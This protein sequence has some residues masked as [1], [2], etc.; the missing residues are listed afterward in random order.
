M[1]KRS[2][3]LKQTLL[4]FHWHNLVRD[5]LTIGITELDKRLKPIKYL[6]GKAADQ[7]AGGNQSSSQLTLF[8]EHKE[9]N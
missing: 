3:K 1:T 9:G 4:A 5:N 8:D 2:K 7:G 6:K